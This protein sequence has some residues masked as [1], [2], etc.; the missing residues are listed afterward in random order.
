MF[1]G[2]FVFDIHRIFTGERTDRTPVQRDGTGVVGLYRQLAV[3]KITNR[4]GQPI[5]IIQPDGI[6]SGLLC[7][8]GA[9]T[10]DQQRD[11]RGGATH[12]FPCKGVVLHGRRVTANSDL[13]IK[14]ILRRYAMRRLA[15]ERSCSALPSG[16]VIAK[17]VKLI[18]SPSRSGEQPITPTNRRA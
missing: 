13:T 10:D 4:A 5:A 16:G 12:S 1:A 14:P 7:P 8:S 18:A 17:S 11:K 6:G 9:A 3:A 15:Q 2:L